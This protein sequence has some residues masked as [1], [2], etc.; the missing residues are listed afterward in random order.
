LEDELYHPK[1]WRPIILALSGGGWSRPHLAVYGHWFTTGHGILSLGQIIQGDVE[2]RLQRRANQEEILHNFIREQ[3]LEAFPAVVIA[4]YVSDGIESLVQCHGMGALR[5]NTV[6]VGWPTD[7]DRAES[8]AATLRT[9]AGLGRS[10]VAVRF[11]DETDDPWQVPRGTIDVWWRGQKNGE[12]MVLLAHLL[13]T[14]TEWRM[15]SLR[16]LRVIE[17]EAGS[18]EVLRHLTKL[19]DASRIR[20]TAHVIVSDNPQQAIH[21]ASRDAALVF[22]GFEA[23]DEGDEEAFFQRMEQ[24]ARPL[25]RVVFV[26]SSG[27]VSL[28]S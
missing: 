3:E 15:H 11:T 9:V 24:W 1:N 7:P 16:L 2:D 10:I 22:L 25:P 23:P 8:L 19:I 17:N 26:D 5:P 20:A 21:Q 14:N 12:L 27:G 28:V 6:L 4:P 13:T 18:E